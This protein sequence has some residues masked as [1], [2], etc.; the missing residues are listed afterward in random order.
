M[1][2]ICHCGRKATMNLRVDASDNTVIEGKSIEIGGN[3][4]Y[5]PLCRKH[6]FERFPKSAIR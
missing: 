1:K 4:R 5:V 6:Y 3:D 2:S